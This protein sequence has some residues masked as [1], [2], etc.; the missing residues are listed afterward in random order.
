M[1]AFNRPIQTGFTLIELLVTISVLGII[2]SIAAP[3]FQNQIAKRKME[4]AFSQIETCFKESRIE[5]NI[6][7][8]PVT[9]RFNTQTLNCATKGNI[10]FA[11]PLSVVAVRGTPSIRF[12]ANGTVNFVGA[13]SATLEETFQICYNDYAQGSIDLTINSRGRLSRNTGGRTC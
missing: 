5:A 8:S 6:T 3:S 4:D 9:V 1:K 2:A 10:E 13:S 7:R 11:P 12:N